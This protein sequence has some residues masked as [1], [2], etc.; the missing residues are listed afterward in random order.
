MWEEAK[1]SFH[2]SRL[3]SRFLNSGSGK[4]LLPPL[5]QHTNLLLVFSL[6]IAGS[7]LDQF[8]FVV[9]IVHSD[10]WESMEK[11]FLSVLNRSSC[12][13]SWVQWAGKVPGLKNEYDY[14]FT[15]MKKLC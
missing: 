9:L 6:M 11:G 4:T 5:L 8:W 13:D 15:V 10:Q 12:S 14:E 3:F 1:T 2:V 7:A